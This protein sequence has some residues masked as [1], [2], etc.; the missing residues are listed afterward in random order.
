MPGT[1]DLSRRLA[2]EAAGTGL[3]L[4]TIVGSGIMAERLADGNAAV[5][6]L[7]NTVATAAILV[8]LIQIFGG[9]S[10]AHFNPAVTL[11]FRLS[12]AI[13]GRTAI[14]YV[15]VQA[16]AGLAGVALAHLMFEVPLFADSTTVRAGPAQWLSEVVASFGLVATIFGCLRARPDAVPV[17]VGLYIAAGYWFTASTGFANPAVTLARS[18]T[19][20]F[21]GIRPIDAP[22]FVLAQCLGAVAAVL[23]W[24]WLD[25]PA[26]A[27]GRTRSALAEADKRV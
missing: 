18:L 21:S 14:A 16:V 22:P 17:A 13:D 6:L 4:A 25:R 2:A 19:D 23:L 15:A 20:T 9:I 10:G 24:R 5:A 3:L 12:G 7:G 1:H 27:A 11:A 8:V 26:T